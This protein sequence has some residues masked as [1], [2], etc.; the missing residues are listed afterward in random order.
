LG[1]D[2]ISHDKDTQSTFELY[3]PKGVENGTISITDG[4]GDVIKTLDIATQSAG[5]HQFQWDGSDSSGEQADSGLYH[6][7]MQYTDTDGNTQQSKLGVYP[8]E[9]VRFDQGDAL[10]KVGSNY[11]PL[12]QVKEVY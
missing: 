2:A 6:I 3:F 5:V 8:I 4:N 11:V 7:N 1:S 9:A 10:V 12:T